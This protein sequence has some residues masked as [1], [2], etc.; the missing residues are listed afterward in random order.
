MADTSKQSLPPANLKDVAAM[1]GVSTTTA[2]LVLNRKTGEFTADTVERVR[3]ASVE[4]NYRP[5]AAARSL[6]S[7][8]TH[9]IGL[10]SHEIATTPYAGAT[11]RGALEAAWKTG[12]VLVLVDTE[13]DEDLEHAAIEILLERQIEGVLYA[14]MKHEVVDVPLALAQVP[15]VLVDA[16]TA[17]TGYASVS[18]DDVG[19]AKTAVTHLIDVGH[20]RI[21]FIQSADDVPAA[22]ERLAGYKEAHTEAAMPIDLSYVVSDPSEG[23]SPDV[24]IGLLTRVDRP[25]AVFCF[26]DRTAC[27][28]YNAAHRLGLSIPGDLSVVGFDNQEAIATRLDPSLTTVQLPH[29]EMGRWAVE[30]L[31]QLMQGELA[32]AIQVRMQ[33]PLV[34]RHSVAPPME[35]DRSEE[36]PTTTKGTQ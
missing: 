2:S 31:E 5:N 9:T 4:L 23:A 19:G 24:A 29:Y 3:H 1:A 36:D 32:D 8:R 25:T 6:R 16:R 14:T 20:S 27:G 22:H 7:Q 17:S 10:I 34:E 30:T 13:G 18:P 33:C 28:V 26:N 12:H 21:A 11:I 35:D 15:T